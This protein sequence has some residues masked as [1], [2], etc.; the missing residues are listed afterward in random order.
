M[1]KTLMLLAVFALSLGLYAGGKS[2]GSKSC[3]NEAKAKKYIEY[4][5]SYDKQAANAEE[6]GNTALADALK[7]CAAAKRKISQGY[8]SGDKSVLN[9]G[10]KEYKEAR[11]ERD[12]LQ[13]KK[14]SC[15]KKKKSSSCSKKSSSTKSWDG[16]LSKPKL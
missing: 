1:K 10:F 13:G 16:K 14:K 5:E 2:C 4:A 9:E 6:K 3:K 12:K 8:S 11:A 15:D 7:K